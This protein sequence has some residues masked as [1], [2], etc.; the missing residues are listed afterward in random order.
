MPA[1]DSRTRKTANKAA[2]S[3]Q[4][5]QLL[6]EHLAGGKFTSLADI[7]GIVLGER[8]WQA[9]R[10]L[11]EASVTT[12]TA[13]ADLQS[14]DEAAALVAQRL[15]KRDENTKVRALEDLSRQ[16]CDL[17]RASSDRI[18]DQAA[19][20]AEYGAFLGNLSMAFVKLAQ[21]SSPKVRLESVTLVS[22]VV[23]LFGKRTIALLPTFI[24]SWLGL[25]GDPFKE[26]SERAAMSFR[27]AFP[28]DAKQQRA[29][30]LAPH[31][32]VRQATE[33]IRSYVCGPEQIAGKT[34][35]GDTEMI[36]LQSLGSLQATVEALSSA[37]MTKRAISN[38]ES[39]VVGEFL[40]YW[41]EHWIFAGGIDGLLAPLLQRYRLVRIHR[42]FWRLVICSFDLIM[43][44]DLG[45]ELPGSLSEILDR[46][47]SNWRAQVRDG[48]AQVVSR[49]VW[50]E[51]DASCH[52]Q[53]W[54]FLFRYVKCDFIENRTIA[55]TISARA[56]SCWLLGESVV[57]NRR[58][59][60]TERMDSARSFANLLP[61]LQA[62]RHRGDADGLS[63]LASREPESFRT[64]M[65]TFE[66]A[67]LEQLVTALIWRTPKTRFP[68]TLVGSSYVDWWRTAL[69]SFL[70]SAL[71]IRRS[72]RRSPSAAEER[73][74]PIEFVWEQVERFLLHPTALRSELAS[75]QSFAGFAGRGSDAAS[76]TSLL[77]D[78][79]VYTA[80]DAGQSADSEGSPKGSVIG[81]RLAAVLLER[82]PAW[83]TATL[84]EALERASTGSAFSSL[85]SDRQPRWSLL[86]H[87][88]V[89]FQS[90]CR[91]VL[92]GAFCRCVE[93][94]GHHSDLQSPQGMLPRSERIRSRLTMLEW[95]L[96]SPVPL[97][98]PYLQAD[99]L[100]D[101][102]IDTWALL[103]PPTGPVTPEN[104][105]QQRY[106]FILGALAALCRLFVGLGSF[107]DE[108]NRCIECC[109]NVGPWLAI[110]AESARLRVQTGAIVPREALWT[111]AAWFVH[112]T[113]E[114]DRIETNCRQLGALRYSLIGHNV[115][116]S[117]PETALL[118]AY[119]AWPDA[120][121]GHQHTS[122]PE[123]AQ[124]MNQIVCQALQLGFWDAPQLE[125]FRLG[126]DAR[127]APWTDETLAWLY[128]RNLLGTVL[129][130]N[131]SVDLSDGAAVWPGSSPPS[132]D[133][134][135]SVAISLL[136]YFLE[137]L[138]QAKLDQDEREETSAF[139]RLV[140]RFQSVLRHLA[141]DLGVSWQDLLYR[142]LQAT[143]SA[144]EGAFADA[145][146][147]L[148]LASVA[149]RKAFLEAL[150]PSLDDRTSPMKALLWRSFLQWPWT[151][152]W[153][154]TRLV[155]WLQ[156]AGASVDSMAITT[157]A[158]VVEHLLQPEDEDATSR[159]A[160]VSVLA[161]TPVSAA[162]ASDVVQPAA[163]WATQQGHSLLTRILLSSP[164]VRARFWE[165]IEDDFASFGRSA[166]ASSMIRSTMAA[167]EVSMLPAKEPLPAMHNLALDLLRSAA[168]CLA[169][170]L[171]QWTKNLQ[172]W[173]RGDGH[174]TNGLD[175]AQEY[176]ET[177]TDTAEML[178]VAMEV[179]GYA[180]EIPVTY[181]GRADLLTYLRSAFELVTETEF[182]EVM[183]GISALRSLEDFPAMMSREI[184][185]EQASIRSSIRNEIDMEQGHIP[186][187]ISSAIDIKRGSTPAVESV[188]NDSQATVTTGETFAASRQHPEQA[189]GLRC[190]E[191]RETCPVS[192]LAQRPQRE[193]WPTRVLAAMLERI[194]QPSLEVFASNLSQ[195]Q[196]T[197]IAET[198]VLALDAN[199]GW[200]VHAAA[201]CCLRA[202][203]AKTLATSCLSSV[204]QRMAIPLAMVLWLTCYRFAEA[205][206][207]AVS[208]EETAGICAPL[209]L[210][211]Q[212]AL[213][214]LLQVAEPN[215]ESVWQVEYPAPALA[216]ATSWM[217]SARKDWVAS[218]GTALNAS[219]RAAVAPFW[220][221]R[222]LPYLLACGSGDLRSAALQL[223]ASRW[224]ALESWLADT[225]LLTNQMMQEEPW[226]DVQPVNP[227]DRR[228][229]APKTSQEKPLEVGAADTPACGTATCVN[230]ATLEETPVTEPEIGFETDA[231]SY[232]E[233]LGTLSMPA[234]GE[235]DSDP[236]TSQT[237]PGHPSGA[238]TA[239][240]DDELNALMNIASQHDALIRACGE[241]LLNLTTSFP[242]T[243]SADREVF[244][245]DM[246]YFG[247]WLMLLRLQVSGRH[248]AALMAPLATRLPPDTME[249]ALSKLLDGLAKHWIRHAPLQSSLPPERMSTRVAQGVQFREHLE[250]LLA[251]ITERLVTANAEP[252]WLDGNALFWE[253]DD[254]QPAALGAR[255]LLL[256]L[257]IHP[258]A[259]QRWFMGHVADRSITQPIETLS[260]NLITPPLIARE[261]EALRRYAARQNTLVSCQASESSRGLLSV[262]GSVA[263]REILVLFHFEDVQLPVCLRLPEVYPWR[264]PELSS[265]EERPGTKATSMEREARHG[266]SFEARY[267]RLFI[268]MTRILQH[269]LEERLLDT[270][271]TTGAPTPPPAPQTSSCYLGRSA[272]VDCIMYWHRRLVALLSEAPEC[273]ICYHVL[274]LRTGQVSRVRCPTCRHR[275]H[276]ACLYRWFS[277]ATHG[278]TCPM[279]RSPF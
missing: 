239:P 26:V 2:S 35:R 182:R 201:L 275:F 167:L 178:Y 145:A 61:F 136:R 22:R 238:S 106:L 245:F 50:D 111:S 152:S 115:E 146:A 274:H 53:V 49:L 227:D 143:W 185:S 5:A 51:L 264:P 197:W 109:S 89:A 46:E 23:R 68:P 57:D 213:G 29:I 80:I 39:R 132:A 192:D 71:W 45:Q 260:R 190:T 87:D 81:E 107:V 173:M 272:L 250:T 34:N 52:E 142:V 270:E 58:A 37:V 128:V 207:Q 194:L 249:T 139:D 170:T 171:P 121:A 244:R 216:V 181:A 206:K 97:L 70:E 63:S 105:S 234:S 269:G 123:T 43:L 205:S 186:T 267:R 96:R 140:H 243:M 168:G 32:V 59:S 24:P 41:L 110:L 74:R 223:L 13:V 225:V 103:H 253:L 259:A 4:A 271:P 189:P 208:A 193:D 55:T 40:S 124:R 172:P 84:W 242:S 266:T 154:T 236:V 56:L 69:V 180:A 135:A 78:V 75:E 27:E 48:L 8:S 147:R 232:G 88:S 247:S 98:Q 163:H 144:E 209:T 196:W 18:A 248:L 188:E 268:H 231:A 67:L 202:W 278:A 28:T 156:E 251:G 241:T 38:A 220:C 114:L 219:I 82:A 166:T 64:W 252:E 184:P 131:D 203:C 120:W 257:L 117:W 215:L 129:C 165:R 72:R 222:W 169:Q 112:L 195:D 158:E 11:P 237:G 83:Y 199:L 102:L 16:L 113:E 119:A 66:D 276:A 176:S 9:E 200:I 36:I 10:T 155:C 19:Y 240:H 217:Q 116:K 47:G 160:V 14:W 6:P 54:Q 79:L 85:A 149:F 65:E 174:G 183:E 210:D 224:D 86:E 108:L 94:L 99:R 221:L 161:Q 130:E 151:R 164:S 204:W 92:G 263:A 148:P 235:T 255:L 159:D 246:A 21:D 175:S 122:W 262:Q 177:I 95:C 229:N 100:Y 157:A 150:T 137:D 212:D 233:L 33:Q 17:E 15:L 134:L 62:L 138:E 228:S 218:S 279:C 31:L 77:F 230:R 127:H 179:L 254:W 3:K 30:L 133:L 162:A 141:F 93:P 198:A 60:L 44:L 7:T 1:P 277:S 191:D 226:L 187:S 256:I 20:A 76:L 73:S 211:A 265:A 214:Y 104:E 125:C 118:L 91:D 12:V 25:L 101:F 90:I 261:L 273:P 42:S 258:L 153:A 126:V